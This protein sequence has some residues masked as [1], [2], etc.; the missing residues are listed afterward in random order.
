MYPDKR[1]GQDIMLIV[2]ISAV[3]A[4]LLGLSSVEFGY[5]PKDECANELLN[6]LSPYQVS[7]LIEGDLPSSYG[8]VA[9]WCAD[10]LD[11]WSSEMTEARTYPE[12]PNS[13]DMN[14]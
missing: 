2:T 8:D 7:Q 5:A 9:S 3:C 1:L 4:L 10:H 6:S 11:T 14:L 12:T 13:Y